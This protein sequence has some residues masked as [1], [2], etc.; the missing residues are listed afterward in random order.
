MRT[1]PIPV[2]DIAGYHQMLIGTFAY[3]CNT[4]YIAFVLH[5]LSVIAGDIDY[6]AAVRFAHR[7]TTAA[8]SFFEPQGPVREYD[9]YTGTFEYTDI[10][11]TTEP[12][13]SV[14]DLTWFK[15]VRVQETSDI[16]VYHP[17]RRAEER[18]RIVTH[19]NDFAGLHDPIISIED[20]ECAWG[21]RS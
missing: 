20:R 3:A 13:I 10:V 14:V 8:P 1:A 18:R 2:P 6:I 17:Y 12:N 4:L 11:D 9:A 7:G 5:V 19:V 16:D 21:L 15:P